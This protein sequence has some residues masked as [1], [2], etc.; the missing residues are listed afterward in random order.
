VNAVPAMFDPEDPDAWHLELVGRLAAGAAHDL[1]NVL[2]AVLGYA[3]TLADDPS[4]PP[5]AR[6]HAEEIRRAGRKGAEVAAYLLA[7]ARGHRPEPARIDVNETARE[8]ERW[9][10][11]LLGP[12]VALDLYLSSEPLCVLAAPGAIDRILLNLLLNARD[13]MPDGGRA[14]LETGRIGFGR[15]TV[16]LAVSDQGVGMT[17]RVLANAGRPLF[18]TKANGTGLGLSSVRALVGECGGT[19]TIESSHGHGS[20]VTIKLPAA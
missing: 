8:A 2:M 15:E 10:R 17:P 4:L 18:T 11:R 12:R 6:E 9:V 20:R 7:I 14:V 19:L 5:W 16:V 3:G 13:A 1:N